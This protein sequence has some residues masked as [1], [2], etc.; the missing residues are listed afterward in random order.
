MMPSSVANCVVFY[1]DPFVELDDPFEDFHRRRLKLKADRAAAAGIQIAPATDIV[2][3]PAAEDDSDEE[4]EEELPKRFHYHFGL[5]LGATDERGRNNSISK[6][7]LLRITHY[8]AHVENLPCH[9]V[10]SNDFNILVRYCYYGSEKKQIEDLDPN[11]FEFK[12]GWDNKD[13]HK[14]G[15]IRRTLWSKDGQFLVSQRSWLRLP[16]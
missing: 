3:A 2:E 8:L 5:H 9:G 1:G 7:T 15:Q 16:P 4:L 14:L 12:S 11:M 13:V 10:L 6:Q